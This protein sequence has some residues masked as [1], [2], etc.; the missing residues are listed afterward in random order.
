VP[1]PTSKLQADYREQAGCHCCSFCL[2]SQPPDRGPSYFCGVDH[3]PPPEYPSG[4]YDEQIHDA[5]HA[6]RDEWEEGREVSPAGI[7]NMFLRKLKENRDEHGS[8]TA[9]NTASGETQVSV[10]R[11]DVRE[12]PGYDQ[13]DGP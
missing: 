4:R 7:C 12:L 10:C 3:L 6:A 5:Y 11:D 8:S 2:I 9:S 1:S 13:G